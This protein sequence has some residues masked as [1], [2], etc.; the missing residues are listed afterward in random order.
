M[1]R[2]TTV[3]WDLD[4]T[5]LDFLYSQRYALQKCFRTAGREIAEEQ[6]ERYSQI[7]DSFWKR[8]ELGEISKERLLRE[9]FVQLFKEYGIE[10]I[11]PGAFQREYEEALGSVVSHKDDS[12]TLC[13]AL[14]GFV[15]QYVVTNGIS[16]TQRSKLKLSGLEEAMDGV[17][18]SEEVG[19]PKPS[20]EFFAYCLERIEEKDRSKILIVGDSLTSDI[21]GGIQ[22]GIATCWY[23]PDTEE[24]PSPYIPAY[25][26]SDLHMI[27]DIL[28]VFD[29]WQSR[30]DKS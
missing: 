28:G 5:L 10:D 29:T 15:R 6:M 20:E 14:N 17:F 22:A 8:Y 23:R 13:K 2:F 7:N 26:I 21:R 9:R 3:L 25:E 30:R 4:G 11:E 27:Y 1:K 16:A 18:I 24:N 12:L 19:A